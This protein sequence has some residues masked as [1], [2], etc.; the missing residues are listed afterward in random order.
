MA[1]LLDISRTVAR[2][3][4]AAPTGIDRVERAYIDWALERDA[5]FLAAI[6]GKQHLVDAQAVRRLIEWLDGEADPP[7]MDLQGALRPDRDERLRRAQSHVRREGRTVSDPADLRGFQVYLNT[8]HDNLDIELMCWLTEASVAR[9]AL[10]HDMIPIDHPEYT[11]KGTVEKFRQKLQA[12]CAA[13]ALICNSEHTRD[14]LLAWSEQEL[15]GVLVAPLGISR[16]TSKPGGAEAGFLCVGTIEPRKNHRLLLD[17]WS[18]FWNRDAEAAP[19]LHIVGRRG[20]DITDL[21]RTLE[22][23]PMMG[24]IVHEHTGLSD[25]KVA[26]MLSEACALLFPSLAEGYGLP[27]AE[28]LAAGCPVIASDLP[29]LREVG[30]AVP[31]YL[32]PDDVAAWRT[33]I[34]DFVHPQ[35][36][37]RAAQLARL[38]DWSPPGWDAHFA[39]V[40]NLIETI[41]AQ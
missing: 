20:W 5:T 40:E 35:S 11:R 17:V 24:R 23:H 37:A 32:P 1:L 2:S 13:S 33:A 16:A 4:L 38:A 6:R 28:A 41:M 7:Q 27:L 36:M 39:K 15:P 34:S 8:G 19:H 18:G 22:T 14:R 21:A 10:L 31:D 25:P 3:R 29:A 9:I 30:G 12:M 26:G